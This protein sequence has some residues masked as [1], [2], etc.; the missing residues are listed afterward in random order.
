MIVGVMSDSHG[1]VDRVER[2]LQ[3]FDQ[4]GAQTLIHC[5]DL[6]SEQVLDALAGRDVWFVWGNV[7][8]VE[9][10]LASYAEALGLHAPTKPPPVRIELAGKRFAISHGHERA[11]ERLVE[12]HF[13]G[14]PEVRDDYICH[15]HTHMARDIRLPSGARLIN[16]GALQR[17]SVHTVATIDLT[18]DEVRHW[19][20]DETQG[21]ESRPM[22]IELA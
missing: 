3:I 12:A 17:A 9:L 13:E 10:G 18:G 11:F 22:A 21:V 6:G 8:V 2:A 15:G 14:A 19:V 20:V 5:G 4:L 16:P 1:R 7:D